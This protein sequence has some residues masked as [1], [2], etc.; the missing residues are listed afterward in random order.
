MDRQ[1]RAIFRRARDLV[2]LREIQSRIDALAVEIERQRDEID[3]ARALA[4]AEEA[5]FHAVRT[6]HYRQL[7]RRHRRAAIIMRVHGQYD[8]VAPLEVAVHPFDLVGIDVRRRHL[9]RRRQVDD[10][11][12]VRARFPDRRHGIDDFLGEVEFGAGKDLRAVLEGPV[13]LGLRGRYFLYL[14]GT[15]RR[16]GL[17]ALLALS[18]YDL[19]E[20]RR[21][22]VIDMDDRVLRTAQ[23]FH[24]ARDEFR[25]RLRQ[26]FHMH[27]VRH[28]AFL[29]QLADE[30]E[31]GVGRGRETRLDFLEADLHQHLE[32]AE[33]PFRVHRLEKRLVAV[34]KIGAHPD[35]RFRD[36]LRRPLPVGQG[37]RREG[38]VFDGR[39]LQH[40]GSRTSTERR[41]ARACVALTRRRRIR[42]MSEG[43]CFSA[44]RR[45]GARPEEGR[46]QGRASGRGRY[47]GCVP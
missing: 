3:I 29:D 36:R 2:D 12:A 23:A 41:A 46:V 4:I 25:P 9:D 40:D 7:R 19:A 5:A 6:R 20:I 43:K 24:R 47:A 30:A 11:L 33:L 14:A 35:R 21:G 16:N 45:R 27:I 26:H 38:A 15:F 8:A 10:D 42:K 37:H 18:E 17:Y 44:L 1:L 22:R 28:A 31:I 13:R 39:V 32:H 34:A